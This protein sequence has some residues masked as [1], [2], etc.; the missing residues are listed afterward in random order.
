MMLRYLQEHHS[1][2]GVRA[3]FGGFTRKYFAECTLWLTGMLMFRS[4]LGRADWSHVAIAAVAWVVLSL[5]I[6][7][8]HGG[9]GFARSAAVSK[10]AGYIA[11]LVALCA[12]VYGVGNLGGGRLMRVNFP[13]AMSD[14]EFVPPNYEAT[15]EFFRDNLRGDEQFY[16]ITGE[17]LWF[18]LLDKPCPT[19]FCIAAMA[20]PP[21]YQRELVHDLKRHNV[22]FIIRSSAHWAN[23]L[24]GIRV[25]TRLPV[26]WDYINKDYQFLAYIDDHEI[27]VRKSAKPRPY[28][29]TT[30][31]VLRGIGAG[32]LLQGKVDKAID[33]FNQAIRLNP[34]CRYAHGGLA[35]AFYLK[36]EYADARREARV[37]Q[38]RGDPMPRGFV[39]A[40]NKKIREGNH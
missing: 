36:R 3:G 27:W 10:V 18:Y 35:V 16:T 9:S 13:L 25:Q 6:L 2:G 19:R 14:A 31:T 15:A 24:D 23:S 32:L 40:L 11:W 38:E 30:A 33:R 8:R 39:E 37:A 1:G 5:V 22:R 12:V 21:F 4:A 34:D 29:V 28:V 26:V 7:F 20:A 17:P